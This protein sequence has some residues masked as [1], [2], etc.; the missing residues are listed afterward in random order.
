MPTVSMFYGVII[1][2]NYNDHNP[3]HI[4][5][6]YQSD[7]AIVDME[8]EVIEGSL[9]RKQLR[10]VQAWVEYRKDEILANWE[11]ARSG[12]KVYRIDPL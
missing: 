10:L 1:T 4:H 2:M 5:V 7:K 12:E 6:K 3:P 8:G 11:L 9:P